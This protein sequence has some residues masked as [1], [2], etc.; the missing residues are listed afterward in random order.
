MTIAIDTTS[1]TNTITLPQAGEIWLPIAEGE[2]VVVTGVLTEDTGL[3]VHFANLD[4]VS[5]AADLGYF[6][7]CFDKRS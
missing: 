5:Y 3:E 2:P 4:S 1:A 7:E 6:L